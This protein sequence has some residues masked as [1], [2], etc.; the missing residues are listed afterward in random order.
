MTGISN[1]KKGVSLSTVGCCCCVYLLHINGATTSFGPFQRAS[2]QSPFCLHVSLA[3]T[4]FKYIESRR[5]IPIHKPYRSSQ[6]SSF[7][8]YKKH[9][10]I[11]RASLSRANKRMDAM[12][13]TIADGSQLMA[14]FVAI[15]KANSL[16]K[17][18][19]LYRLTCLAKVTFPSGGL[20]LSRWK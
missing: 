5:F 8:S 14:A 19:T 3:Q 16:R 7:A 13:Q 15:I 12:E 2:I 1:F 17:S 11:K 4:R 20:S 9:E 18:V 6:H 10:K